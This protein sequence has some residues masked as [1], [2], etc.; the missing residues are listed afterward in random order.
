MEL[1]SMMVRPWLR[2][3]ETIGNSIS[4]WDET[5]RKPF[6]R[7]SM[8]LEVYIRRLNKTVRSNQHNE[9]G[10]SRRFVELSEA[11]LIRDEY[12]P[13]LPSFSPSSPFSW[14][15]PL[16]LLTYLVAVM[17]ARILN[18]NVATRSP[19]RST[20]NKSPF[21]ISFQAGMKMEGSLVS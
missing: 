10:S 1:R 14:F 13:L 7:G 18:P 5:A 19:K 3:W 8:I 4:S 15:I 6:S 2:Q 11:A 12:L 17:K 16:Y 21:T 9:R 20:S